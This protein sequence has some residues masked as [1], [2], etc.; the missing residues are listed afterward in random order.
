MTNEIKLIRD[1]DAWATLRGYVYQIETTIIRWLDLKNEEVLELE[2]GEDIDIVS[3]HLRTL[4]QIKVREGS[5]TLKSKEANE[6]LASFYEHLI[7]N[8]QMNL[9]FRFVTNAKNGKE[10]SPWSMDEKAFEV[11]QSIRQRKLFGDK[12]SE[13]VENIRRL[14]CTISRPKKFNKRTWDYWKDFLD[15]ASETD[16]LNFIDKFEWGFHNSEPADLKVEI[17]KKILQTSY[18][19]N[20]EEALSIYQT[21]FCYLFRIL[22]TKGIKRISKKILLEV[23]E[24][25]KADAAEEFIYKLLNDLSTMVEDHEIR[26]STMESII[27]HD[28]HIDDLIWNIPFKPNPHYIGREVLL[29]DLRE[30]LESGNIAA[31]TQTI[32]GIGGVGK[33]QLVVQYAYHYRKSYKIVWWI[34]A[35]TEE[36]IKIGLS[37]LGSRYNIKS[38]SLDVTIEKVLKRLSKKNNWLLIFDNA[39]KFS[40]LEKFLPNPQE[41]HVLIT[42]RSQ[43]WLNEPVLLSYF[44]PSESVRFLMQR[45]TCKDAS[46]EREA[47]ILAEELGY[48]PLALEHAGAYIKNKRKTFKEYTDMYRQRKLEFLTVEGTPNFYHSTVLTTWDISLEIIKDDSEIAIDILRIIS[49]LGADHIPLDKITEYVAGKDVDVLEKDK[50]LEV[51]VNYSLITFDIKER[52]ASIHRLVQEVIK[53]QM[54]DQEREEYL[55]K[56]INMLSENFIFDQYIRKSWEEC[57]GLLA[58]VLNVVEHIKEKSLVNKRVVILLHNLGLFY[59]HF[60]N[61]L[62]ARDCLLLAKEYSETIKDDGIL[63]ILNALSVASQNLRDYT[64]AEQYINL[65]LAM[66]NTNDKIRATLLSN[67]AN[68][69][70]IVNKEYVIA[71]ELFITALEIEHEIYQCDN[72]H[73]AATRNNM[74]E[75]LK[76]MG[77]YEEAKFQQEVTVEI[78]RQ[79]TK[80]IKT[81]NPNLATRLSNYGGTLRKLNLI[82]EALSSYEEALGILEQVFIGDDYRKAFVMSEYSGALISA[83]RYIE[84][85]HVVK[86]ASKMLKATLGKNHQQ[87]KEVETLV[88]AIYML[89]K[90]KGF[91]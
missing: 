44:T 1:R 83:G 77:K 7:N 2:R 43:N 90:E 41:G 6:A 3:S 64:A 61:Y 85:F 67:K 79:I 31:I 22:S 26:I 33:T 62:E 32:S 69:L 40:D 71:L 5:L 45:T 65:A 88:I 15:G 73:T 8:P 87:T 81:V 25:F 19:K 75:C 53:Y 13:A 23:I 63:A 11:W 12:L 66:H 56:S 54:S 55:I 57:R 50:A 38:E 42:S 10:T 34:N 29:K 86:K 58:H 4:E 60:A 17:E 30:K 68:L 52:H 89:L 28:G 78:E 82:D 48:L 9:G 24:S 16:L 49:F 72:Q 39:N 80:Q 36:A 91:K 27:S 20:A 37:E 21:L 46:Q 70:M 76:A 51:L 74:A 84:A 59:N 35:E 18:A 14:L 47:E